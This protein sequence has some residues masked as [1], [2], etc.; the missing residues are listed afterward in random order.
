MSALKCGS[1]QSHE[2]TPCQTSLND[3]LTF[4]RLSLLLLFLLLVVQAADITILA[5][6]SGNS[7]QSYLVYFVLF[8]VIAFAFAGWAI[9]VCWLGICN[10][11]QD[12]LISDA[13]SELA[14]GSRGRLTAE[15]HTFLTYPNRAFGSQ[16]PRVIVIAPRRRRQPVQ[17]VQA[18]VV[19]QL[20]QAY[21]VDNS[22]VKGAVPHGLGYRNSTNVQDID[23]GECAPW[24]S[25]VHGVDQKDGWVR[26]GNRFL[27]MQLYGV[28]VLKLLESQEE[29]ND[30]GNDLDL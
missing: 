3:S 20:A 12:W 25:I 22:A 7:P 26:V 6:R 4:L 28:T 16:P 9:R 24:G 17:A 14:M 19:A 18:V 27:P 13:C 2:M 23:W 1:V 21:L 10:K 8:A 29:V 5:H 15:Y 11:W 30:E